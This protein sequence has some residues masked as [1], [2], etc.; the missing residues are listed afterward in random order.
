MTAS[1]RRPA[2]VSTAQ[3]WCEFGLTTV[4]LFLVVTIVRWLRVPASPLYIGD[5]SLALWVIG[6]VA[7]L[8]ITGLILSPWGR[9]S[10]GHMNPAVTVA[11]W[12]M[13]V[14]PGMSVL[15]YV[16]AQL[17]GSLLG[18]SLGRL[19][20]GPVVS[21]VGFGALRP[22][23]GWSA[24]AVFLAEAGCVLVLALAVGFLLAYPAFGR[25]LP[26][27]VGAC[28]ALIIV[29][30]GPL[31]GGSANP[32]RQFGPAVLAGR[33]TDLLIYMVAPVVGAVLGASVH[34]LLYRRFRLR[35]PITYKLAGTGDTAGRAGAS[36]V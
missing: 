9:R 3:V 6:P 30:F 19:V 28:V 5:L 17:A 1:A 24:S 8:L 13:D 21:A 18:A 32:A 26:A 20:W 16:A 31:S 15:P 14:F 36:R 23:P 34:H 11:V 25:W 10:G 4:L 35:E 27:T 29:V 33:F 22:A 2:A 7:G 12:L